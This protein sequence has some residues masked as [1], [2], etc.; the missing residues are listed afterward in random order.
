MILQEGEGEEEEEKNPDLQQAVAI[1]INQYFMLTRKYNSIFKLINA[2]LLLDE[3]KR[4]KYLVITLKN[5]KV[6]MLFCNVI[7]SNRVLSSISEKVETLK[8]SFVKDK[9]KTN[10]EMRQLAFLST[11]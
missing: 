3:L 11:K 9:N 7:N 1:S 5:K 2:Q 10:S 6:I 4:F 8:L